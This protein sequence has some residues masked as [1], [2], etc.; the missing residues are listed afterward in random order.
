M[1]SEPETTRQTESAYFDFLAHMGFTKHIGALDATDSL[2]EMCHIGPDSSVLYVGCGVGATPIYLVRKHGCR[3]VGVDITPRMI[4]RANAR[5]RS[6]GVADRTEFR[7]ADM[8]DLPFESDTFDAVMA[9]SVIAFS[10][11]PGSVL[12]E[13]MRV[14]K[15]GGYVGI[16]EG[17]WTKPDVPD[18]VK[19]ALSSSAISSPDLRQPEEWTQIL[20]DAGLVE[21]VGE[22][23][24]VDVR[25][26]ASGRV[27]RL[28]CLTMVSVLLRFPLLY[29]RHPEYRAIFKDTLSQTSVGKAAAYTGYGVY[30]GRKPAS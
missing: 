11:V 18:D 24:T 27:K 1:R 5:A 19:A 3:V 23:R 17:T 12:R 28:G 21:V 13:L 8:H 6:A 29:L 14:A 16:T 2:I 26:E 10:K 7:V 15:P 30:A 25:K 4:E 20:R 22:G 9:E